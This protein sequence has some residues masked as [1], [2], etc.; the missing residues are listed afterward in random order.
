MSTE[1]LMPHSLR[2]IMLPQDVRFDAVQPGGRR[3]DLLQFTDLGPGPS[4]GATFNVRVAQASSVTVARATAELR[5][6]F[7]AP[8]RPL[9]P[10]HQGRPRLCPGARNHY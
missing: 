4:H 8:S 7:R 6:S 1:H 5:A 2:H 3:G 10:I 9:P